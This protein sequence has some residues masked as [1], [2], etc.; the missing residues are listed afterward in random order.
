MREMHRV[1][2]EKVPDAVSMLSYSASGH[3]TPPHPCPAHPCTHQPGSSESRVSIGISFQGHNWLKQWLLIELNLQ[4]PSPSPKVGLIPSNSKPQP[5][6]STICPSGDRFLAWV[7][8]AHQQ[9]LRCDPWGS[10]TTKTLLWLR[11]VQGFRLSLPGTWDEDQA[12]ASW[13]GQGPQPR[14]TGELWL[15]RYLFPFLIFHYFF[16]E[17]WCPKKTIIGYREILILF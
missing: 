16:R 5:S 1:K 17:N 6:I 12:D 3:M 13:Q 9:K 14:S 8:S 7:I 2:T 15:F 4:L 11:K 10:T